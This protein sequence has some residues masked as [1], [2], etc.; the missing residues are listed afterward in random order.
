MGLRENVE[1]FVSWLFKDYTFIPPNGPKIIN[2]SIHGNQ[3]FSAHEIAV[4]DTPL[5]QRLKQIK[6]T[7]LV[8]Q[9]FPSAQHT[10]FEHS[11]GVVTVAERCLG[12]IRERASLEKNSDLLSAIQLNRF[13]GDLAELRLAALLHD[14]GHGL[15]SHASEQISKLYQSHE[16]KPDDP[17]FKGKA[18]GEVVSYLMIQS[19]TFQDW[20]YEMVETLNEGCT[21]EN[22]RISIDLEVAGQM[23]L[24]KHP[25]P[26]KYFLSQ[27]I[28]S[29][30]DADKLDYIARDSF[31]CGLA[32]TVD[33][34]RFYSMI[35][36]AYVKEPRPGRVL[37]LRTPAPLEQ[38]LFSKMTLFSS[39]YHHQKVKAIDHMLRSTLKYIMDNPDSA[40]TIGD[41]RVRYTTFL[42]YLYITDDQFFGFTDGFGDAFTKARLRSFR[43]RNLF[44]R[45]LELSSRTITDWDTEWN[46]KA[47]DVE[48][49]AGRSLLVSLVDD[50]LGVMNVE[51]KIHSRLPDEVKERCSKYDIV[52]SVPAPPDINTKSAL[53]QTTPEAEVHRITAFF[54]LDQWVE[55]YRYNKWRAYVYAPLEYVVPVRNAAKDVFREDFHI[56]LDIEKSDV[57]CHVN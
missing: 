3:Y 33:L 6:Q 19:E 20:F 17:L 27:I 30:F 54:P 55:A 10:R 52:L 4:I 9:V 23:I 38:I 18:I 36:A 43:N 13:N 24:G 57:A 46:R 42:D 34:P 31:Y 56:P 51:E 12:A 48:K 41:K 39:V 21:D 44:R 50:F 14:V 28:S 26:N 1:D 29:P 53:I 5:L 40:P 47:R 45:C 32:L 2:D 22:A 7:G 35:T 15:C 11:L 37:V 25:D 16:E 49:S 8:W